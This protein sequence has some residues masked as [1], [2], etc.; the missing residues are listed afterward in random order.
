V[1]DPFGIFYVPHFDKRERE[2][3]NSYFVII[4]SDGSLSGWDHVSV[5]ARAI[6][7]GKTQMRCP[8]WEEM[9]YL[10]DLFFEKDECVMQL[11]PKE[12]DYVNNH[13]YVLHLW[14]PVNQPIPTPPKLF[15]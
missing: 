9:C 13:P 14:R 2:R 4:A 8:T 3:Y 11:H 6:K 5:H 10:K 12:A 1:G 15:V 7:D